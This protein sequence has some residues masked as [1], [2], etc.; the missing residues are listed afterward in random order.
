MRRN[1]QPSRPNAMTCSRFSLLKTWLM[2]TEGRGSADYLEVV[3]HMF[4]ANALLEYVR[5]QRLKLGLK[6]YTM[7]AATTIC[8]A[9]APIF[10]SG[11]PSSPIRVSRSRTI[12]GNCS[13]S[14]EIHFCSRAT[15][16]SQLLSLLRAQGRRR[17]NQKGQECSIDLLRSIKID[18]HTVVRRTEFIGSLDR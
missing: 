15:R 5:V 13:A 17:D 9:Q 11:S 14:P 16:P 18:C 1:D 12:W 7:P 6:T 10:R 2:T 3:R 4:A 8:P